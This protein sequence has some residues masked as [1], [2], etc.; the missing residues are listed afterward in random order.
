MSGKRAVSPNTKRV[1][2]SC[3]A[4]HRIPGTY[5][6]AGARAH[7]RGGAVSR[8]SGHRLVVALH[9]AGCNNNSNTAKGLEDGYTPAHAFEGRACVANAHA[10]V[11]A[12]TA[13]LSSATHPH[14]PAPGSHPESGQCPP[15]GGG[16][17]TP[18]LSVILLGPP[19]FKAHAPAPACRCRASHAASP[20]P[21]SPLRSTC[22][23]LH[24][25]ARE[26]GRSDAAHRR[27]HPAQRLKG[28][29]H[30]LRSTAQAQQRRRSTTQQHSTAQR[31][32]AG[33]QAGRLAGHGSGAGSAAER[34]HGTAQRSRKGGREAQQRAS[35][36][37]SASAS[38]ARVCG[39]C[40]WLQRIRPSW[41]TC[42]SMT[43]DE[44]C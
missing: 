8:E 2:K 15:H 41:R 39:G 28:A 11:H 24:Q 30:R 26:V 21:A 20:P 40:D 25:R 37:R 4:L 1:P 22:T 43:H 7:G 27:R 35:A 19:P 38:T 5:T 18:P 23:H 14:K 16:F 13:A 6:P 10:H 29:R 44:R 12:R 42:S 3:T 33:S 17:R 31:S 36:A 32:T 34:R 9:G